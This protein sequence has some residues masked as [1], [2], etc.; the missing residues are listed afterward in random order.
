M[1]NTA[2]FVQN[3]NVCY[4]HNRNRNRN[5]NVDV[6]HV[7]VS[8]CGRPHSDSCVRNRVNGVKSSETIRDLSVCKEVMTE[9]C[10][11]YMKSVIPVNRF[12]NLCLVNALRCIKSVR[13]RSY[14]GPYFPA[15][16]LN[17]ERYEV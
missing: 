2:V 5:F 7:S 11:L 14:S 1:C 6:H 13:I 4:N 15:F 9:F 3:V 12:I 16:R 8:F 10:S 17:M